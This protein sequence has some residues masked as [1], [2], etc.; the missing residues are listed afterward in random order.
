MDSSERCQE[1]LAECRS[2]MPLAQSAAE[3]TVLKNLGRSWK[4]ICNQ[5][6]LYE[7]ILADRK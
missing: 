2:L 6:E 1:Q 5:L 4:M 3:A 7:S